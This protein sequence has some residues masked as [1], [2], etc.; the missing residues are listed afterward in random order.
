MS[1][2][3]PKRV[4]SARFRNYSNQV[5]L[6]MAGC[7]STVGKRGLLVRTLGKRVNCNLKTC[8]RSRSGLR[9]LYGVGD[10]VG[11]DKDPDDIDMNSPPIKKYCKQVIGG[12]NGTYCQW[13]QPRNRQNAGGVGHIWTSRRNH[14][15]KT[16]A[17]GWQENYMLKYRPNHYNFL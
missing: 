6:K 2:Y 14:C 7:P 5:G 17:L 3:V 11:W 4:R 16:C 9:C 12:R 10:A 15:E 1:G 13:P 8:G